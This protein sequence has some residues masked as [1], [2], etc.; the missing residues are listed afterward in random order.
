MWF[1]VTEDPV[2]ELTTRPD[3]ARVVIEAAGE[4]DIAT[5]S[6]LDVVVSELRAAG[7]TNVVLDLRHVTFM[8]SNGLSWLLTADR[9]ARAHAGTLSIVDG[10]AAVARSGLQQ[11]FTFAQGL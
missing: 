1:Q 6:H 3:R 10:S 9:D 7:W 4:I 5:V 2:L 8:D 11:H